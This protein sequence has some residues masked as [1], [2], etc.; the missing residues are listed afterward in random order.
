VSISFTCI[1]ALV[2]SIC[3]FNTIICFAKFLILINQSMFY[4]ISLL[5]KLEF[6]RSVIRVIDG[7]EF[8]W[9]RIV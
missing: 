3:D 8:R 6:G 2:Y 5:N 1:V 7:L 4:I 9:V